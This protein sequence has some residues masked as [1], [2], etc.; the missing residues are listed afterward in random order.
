[1]KNKNIIL[2]CLFC[3]LCIGIFIFLFIKNSDSSQL[4][5][6]EPQIQEKIKI[7][8][9]PTCFEL[10]KK[11]DREKY[12]IIKTSSTSESID[13][14][15]K[16]QADMI[17]A[18]RTLKPN[19]PEFDSL[20]IAEGYSFLSSQESIIYLDQLNDFNIYTDLDAEVL[21]NM[22][23]IQKIEKIDDIYEYL[24]KGI[25]ITSWENTDYIKASIVHVLENNGERA[26]LSRRPTVYCPSICGKE[27]QELVLLLENK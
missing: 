5:L 25:V 22:F 21:K 26:K 16:G 1:M 4:T 10:S 27:A 9:C 11:L 13:L 23:P 20:L 3:C 12:Q 24:D 2:I 17:L 15:N 8:A 6:N 14:L 18:G 19:E 7:A